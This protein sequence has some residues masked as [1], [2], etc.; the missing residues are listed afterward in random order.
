MLLFIKH[1]V[2]D[3]RLCLQFQYISC[4]YLSCFQSFLKATI[5]TFQYISC[6]YLSEL[7]RGY[8]LCSLVSIHLMLLFILIINAH[9]VTL[10]KFQY[11]SCCYLSKRA[12]SSRRYCNVSIHLM[13]LFIRTES[14]EGQR[15]IRVSI[16]LML[17]FL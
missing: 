1:R 8:R 14:P 3:W 13:L 7:N 4:C 2:Q 15:G 5:L 6:C 16:H 9:S 11:I 12:K 10:C 17:L